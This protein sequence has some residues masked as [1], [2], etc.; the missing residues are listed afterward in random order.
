LKNKIDDERGAI[1]QIA[2]LRLKA[3]GLHKTRH[4]VSGN[5]SYQAL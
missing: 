4:A 3:T 1:E 2:P 5:K